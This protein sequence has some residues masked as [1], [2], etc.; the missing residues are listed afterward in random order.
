MFCL[1][2]TTFCHIASAYKQRMGV[3][4]S[5]PITLMFDGDR[6]APLDTIAD[7]EVED[8]DSIDVVLN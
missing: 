7:S 6:L 1:Q 8:M 3:A 4:E 5:Q 2:D